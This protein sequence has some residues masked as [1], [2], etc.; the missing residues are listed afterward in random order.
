M[1]QTIFFS[2]LFLFHFI[3][4]GQPPNGIQK[5]P[6]STNQMGVKEN[7]TN[8]SKGKLSTNTIIESN[9]LIKMDSSYFR[10]DQK[11]EERENYSEQDDTKEIRE[12]DKTLHV[13]SA[14]SLVRQNSKAN[15][16]Q[17]TPLA[18][19]QAEMDSKVKQLELIS[20]NS[21]E[22]QLAY[23]AA[24]NYNLDRSPSLE[25]AYQ[26]NP[27]NLEV[28]KQYVSLKYMNGD[29][30]SAQNMLSTMSLNELISLEAERYTSDVLTSCSMNSTLI[31]HG[32][33]DTYGALFN[34]FSHQQ[35]MDVNVISLDFLQ[36]PQYRKAL[37]EKGY[38]LPKSTKID[39]GYLSQFCY[40]NAKKELFLSVTIPRTYLD[41]LSKKLFPVGLTFQ[42]VD[43]P[44]EDLPIRQEDLWF[45]QLNKYGLNEGE[46][47]SKFAMNYMPMLMYLEAKYVQ[48]GNEVLLLQI[49]ESMDQ[50]L[51]RKPIKKAGN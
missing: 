35:R 32:F 30:L 27:E 40:L 16:F 14:F 29:T 22:Y 23:Y 6:Q 24:G 12:N 21:W 7:G 8:M 37:E 9:G 13:F 25:K 4:F 39:V 31:T 41:P 26:M 5:T 18:A 28:Q 11:L 49:R 15:K 10:L 33:E 38:V 36:S 47:R 48:E 1:K 42:Y 19:E 50:I 34:Q 43:A 20:P 44:A 3:S 51:G 45:Y 2:L 17:R 46:E